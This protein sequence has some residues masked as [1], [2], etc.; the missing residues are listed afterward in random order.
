MKEITT[1][2][3][4][5]LLICGIVAALL[6]GVNL[7]TEPIIAANNQTTFEAAMAEVLPEASSFDQLSSEGFTPSETGVRLDSIYRA[8][9]GGY[10]VSTVCSEGYGGD[11]SVMVG[12]TADLKVKQAKVMSM[13]ETPGLGAKST[14]PKFIDQYSGLSGGV[15]VI[16]NSAPAGNEIEAISGATITSKAVTKAVNAAL[17]AAEAAAKSGTAAQKGG[18][19]A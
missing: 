16:K 2:T 10:V 3:V 19:N 9:G 1:L 12:I 8:G 11:I 4:K 14:E 6:A 7:V 15:Q 13:S 5:L 18:Q 17:E